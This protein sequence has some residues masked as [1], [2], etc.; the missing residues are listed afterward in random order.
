[1]QSGYFLWVTGLSGSGKTAVAN[2]VAETLR[3]RGRS[4]ILL[5]GDEL[6]EI[7]CL[8]Q[9]IEKLRGVLGNSVFL[10]VHDSFEFRHYELLPKQV[11]KLIKVTNKQLYLKINTQ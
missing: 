8:A 3:D 10:L 6:R 2:Q 9:I 4:V 1:M 7:L 5:N 11:I